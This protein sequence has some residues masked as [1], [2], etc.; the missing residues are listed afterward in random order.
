[1]DKKVKTEEIK[2]DVMPGMSGNIKTSAMPGISENVKTSAMPGMSENSKTSALPNVGE[3]GKN[4][5][6]NG[7]VQ[8]NTRKFYGNNDNNN[9]STEKIIVNDRGDKHYRTIGD[10][11]NEG[12]EAGLCHVECI[13]T[14]KQYV[15]K[16]YFDTRRYNKHIDEFSDAVKPSS[17]DGL[18]ELCDRGFVEGHGNRVYILPDYSGKENLF[19]YLENHTLSEEKIIELIKNISES[20]NTM[21]MKGYYHRDIKPDNILYGNLERPI[22]IDYGI[23]TSANLSISDVAVTETVK[24]T[25]G[26]I[27]PEFDGSVGESVSSGDRK[28]EVMAGPK[29]D[30]F[31]LGIV[32]CDIYCSMYAGMGIA[33]RMFMSNKETSNSCRY[34]KFKFPPNLEKNQRM[35]NLVRALLRFNF[36]ERAGYKEVMAWLDGAV[37]DVDSPTG[38][39][40][41]A[42]YMYQ[43]DSKDCHS[44][45]ELARAMA[46]SWKKGIEEVTRGRL[47]ETYKNRLGMEYKNSSDRISNIEYDYERVSPDIAK[48]AVL[49]EIIGF[50]GRNMAF[51]WKGYIYENETGNTDYA[52]LAE[53][54]YS[55]ANNVNANNF[56]ELVSSRALKE[57]LYPQIRFVDDSSSDNDK[58]KVDYDGCMKNIR[59]LNDMA[60]NSME[61]AKYYVAEL[62]YRNAESSNM[63]SY[64]VGLYTKGKTKDLITFLQDTFS[65]VNID[66]ALKIAN[67]ESDD[68]NNPILKFL[69]DYKKCPRLKACIISAFGLEYELLDEI[70]MTGSTT[71][72]ILELIV[73]LSFCDEVSNASV[74]IKDIFMQTCYVNVICEYIKEKNNWKYIDATG[75]TKAGEYK[76]RLDQGAEIIE[77]LNGSG[78]YKIFCEFVRSLFNLQNLIQDVIKIF[79]YD[80]DF[81]SSGLLLCTQK[82]G[83]N[84]FLNS[85]IVAQNEKSNL[86]LVDDKF[87]I[88][89]EVAEKNCK[90]KLKISKP[91]SQKDIMVYSIESTHEYAKRFRNSFRNLVGDGID[92]MLK[93]SK[94]KLLIDFII[95]L[96]VVVLGIGLIFSG[97]MLATSKT[98]NEGNINQTVE[99]GTIILDFV[100]GCSFVMGCKGD[101]KDAW[102]NLALFNNNQEMI[103][104]I[105]L[106][107]NMINKLESATKNKRML[108]LDVDEKEVV[109]ISGCAGNSAKMYIEKHHLCSTNS[110][111]KASRSFIL[112]AVGIIGSALFLFSHIPAKNVFGAMLENNVK[113][114][115]V[116]SESRQ[117]LPSIIYVIDKKVTYGVLF[118]TEA[119][120]KISLISQYNAENIDTKQF[121]ER[122]KAYYSLCKKAGYSI[123]AGLLATLDKIDIS[124]SEYIK[125][126][127]IRKSAMLTEKKRK[128]VVK[129]YL[130]VIPEDSNYADA[131]KF[132]DSYLN[133]LYK[134]QQSYIE[135]DNTKALIKLT[136]KYKKL[137]KENVNGSKLKDSYN[138]LNCKT[139]TE[140]KA[141]ELI[142]LQLHYKGSDWAKEGMLR[143]SCQRYARGKYYV[144]VQKKTSGLSRLFHK[145]DTEFYVFNTY[146]YD[147]V[148]DVPND[149][150]FEP[151]SFKPGI[152]PK[153]YLALM[154]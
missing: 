124:K 89:K 90:N 91:K 17:K 49:A 150:K 75:N 63:D 32:I 131:Q 24:G 1:M 53:D 3:N 137:L 47:G 58:Q 92:E 84:V 153:K 35:V 122:R 70:K 85:A 56:D 61:L 147:M 93:K 15:A 50:L 133:E 128:T 109:K 100:L 104:K 9:V 80:V 22:I 25:R 110:S 19:K 120:A 105:K 132:M 23:V 117:S 99:V 88:P 125:G 65:S 14:N 26:Y 20:L 62:C 115:E 111:Y 43:F 136:A 41:K 5:F 101:L 144:Q 139:D 12:G 138:I 82:N 40:K 98:L 114:A 48:H 130:N 2:T 77:K 121:E 37:L 66:S 74:G 126:T 149:I 107:D 13:E 142:A 11:F 67:T 154:G 102:D 81:A 106:I 64:I 78:N 72:Q 45:E 51:A 127:K 118:I 123:D 54:L 135:T 145:Y 148:T 33:K 97:I 27:P 116:F 21:H 119:N 36:V 60:K 134:K 42:Q 8:E 10:Y 7:A 44:E 71:E 141:K 69:N 4:D 57:L 6:E 18:M 143:I 108:C 129:H 55:D 152:S 16:I 112:F 86:C 28:I 46:L 59:Y 29:Y 30:F 103:R 73:L 140:Q 79:V 38:K 68:Y 87:L 95:A 52:S 76:K 113:Q 31:Q 39:D 151:Q 146:R 34:A 94:M 83:D 96:I